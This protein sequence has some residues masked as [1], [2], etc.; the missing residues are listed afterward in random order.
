MPSRKKGET[1]SAFVSRCIGDAGMTKEFPKKAQ[2]IAVCISK[3]KESAQEAAHL[4]MNASHDA[5]RKHLRRSLE[6]VH[7]LASGQYYESGPYVADIFPGF[8]IYEFQGIS[9]KRSYSVSYGSEGSDPKIK[10]G[11]SKRV[12]VAYVDSKSTESDRVYYDGDTFVESLPLG[13]DVMITLDGSAQVVQESVS[14]EEFTPIKEAA[15]ERVLVKIIG[16]GWGSMAY[17][18]ESMIKNSGPVAFRKGTHMYWNHATASE[19]ADR[20]EGIRDLNELTAITTED[21]Y[22][23]KNG[24]KG[25][26]LYALTKVFS[27][28]ATQLGEKGPHIGVSINAALKG[29]AGEAEGKSGLIADEFVHGF[30]ADFVTKAGAGGAPVLESQREPNPQGRESTMNTEEIKAAEE[31][32]KERD[33]LRM[34][35]SIFK[36]QLANRATADFR[37]FAIHEVCK[38]LEEGEIPFRANLV[39]RACASPV[40]KEGKV[41]PEWIKG[42]VEDFSPEAPGK[43]EGMGAEHVMESGGE[44]KMDEVDKRL[45]GSLAE[46]GIPEAGLDAAV[47]GR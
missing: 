10:L 38:V 13:Q 20:P 35:N 11:E 30:S 17:Y 36:E 45:R 8:V 7:G 19:E 9:Y 1:D 43:V 24:P 34:E 40:I 26:G 22:Y 14:F 32:K 42:I 25:S 6:E 2:R 18:S 44:P 33:S 21:A 12:H 41:D 46:L 47:A 3:S 15:V 39:A 37:S 27:D 16:P 4:A 23:D 29:H 5:L 28:H 31:T